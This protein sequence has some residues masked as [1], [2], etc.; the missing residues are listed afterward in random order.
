MFLISFIKR[1]TEG[2]NVL[3]LFFV[4]CSRR[5][6]T[7]VELYDLLWPRVLQHWGLSSGWKQ[8]ILLSCP[9]CHAFSL[10][11]AGGPA[12]PVFLFFSSRTPLNIWEL[13]TEPIFHATLTTEVR[14]WSCEMAPCILKFCWMDVCWWYEPL[15]GRVNLVWCD[16]FIHKM[17][18]FYTHWGSNGAPDFSNFPQR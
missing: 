6:K 16:C 18:C 10:Y 2:I 3:M 15:F 7:D 13:M 11:K 17:N 5:P 1:S 4:V 12:G 9:S 8:I 14:F